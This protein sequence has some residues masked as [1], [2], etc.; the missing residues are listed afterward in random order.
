MIGSHLEDSGKV[1]FPDN[2]TPHSL[3][4]IILNIAY[5]FIAIV[6]TSITT[7]TLLPPLYYSHHLNCNY[8]LHYNHHPH[9]C[10]LITIIHIVITFILYH[11]PHYNHLL[12]YCHFHITIACY[13]YYH[14]TQLFTCNSL[15][16]L[17]YFCKP[18]LIQP[19]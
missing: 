15:N 4:I 2:T 1:H 12:H 7:S 6:R 18:I 11:H 14:H 9:Y 10:H 17:T 3:P 16:F 8:H 13:H 5:H 19:F